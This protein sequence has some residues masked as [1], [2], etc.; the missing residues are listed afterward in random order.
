[1]GWCLRCHDAP[2]KH[3]RPV[4]EVTNLTWAPGAG[5]TPEEVGTEVK[6]R[7]QVNAPM[8]CQSCHR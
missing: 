3:L 5:R 8:H 7:L 1:M 2:E 6:E 4:S